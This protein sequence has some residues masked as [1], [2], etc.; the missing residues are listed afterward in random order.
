MATA[1]L[2]V[3]LAILSGILVGFFARRVLS[4]PA[5]W[6]RSIVVGLAVFATSLPFATWM[7]DQTGLLTNGKTVDTAAAFAALAVVLLSIGWI[8]ALGLALLV[9]TEAVFPTRQLQNPLDIIRAAIKQRKRTRRYLQIIG[10]ASRHGAGWLIEGRS[11]VHDDL[12]TS[13]QRARAVIATINDSGVTFV[14]LGQVMSTR[15]DL[16]PEPYLSALATLQSEATML[17]WN[18]IRPVIAAE[19]E[20]PIDTIFVSID[21]E[22]LAAASVAQ[23]H[24]AVLHDGTAVVVKVQ[25]PAARAQVEADADIIVRLAERAETHTRFGR[26][27][28]L[29][30]VARSFTAT[31]LDELDYRVE[32]TNV[33]MIR[34]TLK[35]QAGH[36][37]RLQIVV[38]RVYPN[39]SGSRVL[40]MDL[41]AGEPLSRA[42][43]LI[44]DMPRAQ[45]EALARGLMEVVLEQILVHGVFHADLHPGN[46]ILRPDGSLG[47]IDF[48]AVGVIE[49]SQRQRLAAVMLAA[50][51]EDDI[52]ATEALLLIVDVPVD[53]DIESLRHDVGIVVTTERY[54]PRGDGS[55]FTRLLDVIRHHRIALPGDLAAAFRSFATL[56]GCLK[57]LD[58][59]FDMF[60]QALP[61]VPKLLRRSHSFQ[62]SAVS[63]Q[64]QASVAAAL[65]RGI[66]RRLD[67]LLSGLENGTAGVT[68]RALTDEPAQNFL[69]KITAE[70]VGTFVSIAAVVVA[71]VLIVTDSGPLLA[72]GLRLFDLLGALIGFFGFLG[73]LRVLRQT[74]IRRRRRR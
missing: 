51:S 38:P 23:V 56:E 1:V 32:A 25:R 29:A 74:A 68:L 53:A 4:T 8:F 21:H 28:N 65:L 36:P 47:L 7:L 27:L 33:E 71:V 12:T 14:K 42:S 66:P 54:R 18:D 5:G 41:V 69:Q 11:R 64:A 22:P 39:A 62:H 61:M 49:R 67:S 58:P 26:D 59:D 10:I 70:I 48:G 16:V 24:K 52:A 9:A 20:A 6:P 55:I 15:R 40:T 3:A 13:E 50:I 2:T 30:A 60:D 63:L 34:N 43:V 72:G 45:R 46:V 35:G 17:P 44:A 37:E 57:A 73:V 31:L 19:L